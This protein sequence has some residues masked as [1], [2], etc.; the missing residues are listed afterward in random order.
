MAQ[1]TV[2][3]LLQIFKSCVAAVLPQNLIRQTVKYNPA[4]QELTI[5]DRT[6]DL[7]KENIYLAGTGKA[8]QHMAREIEEILN[9][10]IKRGVVSIPQGSL[11]Q[12]TNKIVQYL[13]GA[14]NNLPDKNAVNT[15]IKIKEMATKLNKDELLLVLISGGGSA[16]LSLPKLPVTLD[17]K[18]SLIKKLA[19]SGADIKELNTVRKKLSDIKGGQLAIAAQPA[20]VISLILSDIVDDP[21][22]LIA[23]GPTVENTDDYLKALSII[24][25]Y[26]LYDTL[27]ESI[28]KVL[29]S[30][31][32]ERQFP[33]NN[34]NNYII[35]SNKLSIKAGVEE[36]KQLNYHP[37]ELSNSV[38]GY[39]K[40]I[41][42]KYAVLTKVY[43]EL[44]EGKTNIEVT[45]SNI[46]LLKIPGLNIENIQ[47]TDKDICL[48][49]GGEI[50]VK[51]TGNGKGGRNQEL[52]LQFS[53]DI[54]DFKDLLH[55]F[56]V[57]FLSAGTDG[58][59]GPTDAAGAIGYLG[60]IG[61]AEKENVAVEKFILDNDSYN[62]YKKFQN[63]CFHVITG[64]TGTN[65]MDIHLIVIKRKTK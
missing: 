45:K 23:S 6:Y 12:Y 50:T 1:S 63:G 3:D 40:D 28:R 30:K 54:N 29:E 4:N 16:L 35:G 60:L 65:V 14:S 37:I 34:V 10:K 18:T 8:V 33:K 31:E 43:C 24:K 42:R 62:F 39:L 22:D 27:P 56:E 46:Q 32:G 61:N 44:L 19:N 11:N 15:S 20:K 52:A 5:V 48:I 13:E 51:V 59:D 41:S 53:K 49:L 38:T 17:E 64:H 57:Y 47:F 7:Q 55:N 26:N 9:S 36:A 21:I 2:R 25:K 58:I